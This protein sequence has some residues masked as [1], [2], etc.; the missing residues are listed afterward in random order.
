MGQG[1]ALRGM[2]GGWE[3]GG[4]RSVRGEGELRQWSVVDLQKLVVD[5]RW[6]KTMVEGG[7]E[8]KGAG[9]RGGF[10]EVGGRVEEAGG[11]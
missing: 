11:G 8:S 4:G 1:C 5:D 7:E 3:G 6:G 2:V 10:E 9:R